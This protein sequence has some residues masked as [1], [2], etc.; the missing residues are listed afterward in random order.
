MVCLGWS[1]MPSC[2]AEPDSQTQR[3]RCN[4]TFMHQNMALLS[5]AHRPLDAAS[6][7]A[8][9]VLGRGRDKGGGATEYESSGF[10]GGSSPCLVL[11][12]MCMAYI[13]LFRAPRTRCEKSAFHG[14]VYE[15]KM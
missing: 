15:N 10:P 6:N 4:P 11:D 2:D 1:R 8:A 14:K 5:V 9:A 7:S 13:P 3:M 12:L